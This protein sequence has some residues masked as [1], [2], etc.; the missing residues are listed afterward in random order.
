MCPCHLLNLS[1]PLFPP[2]G[3]LGRF[4]RSN[5]C[6]TNCLTLSVAEWKFSSPRS[7]SPMS[8][9]LAVRTRTLRKPM[10]TSQSP[11]GPYPAMFLRDP[12]SGCVP[13][14]PEAR[15]GGFPRPAISGRD[16]AELP[17]RIRPPREGLNSA[18]PKVFV[19]KTGVDRKARNCPASG[20]F[21]PVT[22]S[23]GWNFWLAGNSSEK[24][25]HLR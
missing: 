21:A 25:P 12:A 1:G 3:G 9:P 6:K 4:A 15:L 13:Y 2:P 16:L 18:H 10:D 24:A 5:A 19:F 23:S 20:T 7:P 11:A 8:S 14:S 22:V 17:D